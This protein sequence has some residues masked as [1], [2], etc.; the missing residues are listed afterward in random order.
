[1]TWRGWRVKTIG[2]LA[3]G[4]T[5]TVLVGAYPVTTRQ[6]VNYAVSEHRLPLYRKALDFVERSRRYQQLA[7]EAVAGT[8][9]PEA[10][11]VA[12]F[13]WT[14]AHVKPTPDGVPVLDD[15][16]LS[17]I[18]RGHGVADQQADVF[19]TLT[20]YAGVPAF[21]LPLKP[22]PNEGGLILSFVQIGGRWCLF[23]VAGN[24]VYR[25]PDGR[26]ATLDDVR[27]DPR[28]VPETIR[29]LDMNGTPYGELMKRLPTPAVPHPLRAELQMP[30]R[31]VW[32]ELKAALH[33]EA[34]DD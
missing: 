20:T 13:A 4:L 9:D 15:H 17:I 32:H 29:T 19:A 2:A 30:G 5:L 18:E 10:R 16:I 3:A 25:H 31:R 14:R 34:D 21:W 12:A 28:L 7:N 6:G 1:M 26:L 33:L 22:A 24:V 8:S 23:D 11:A 27:A